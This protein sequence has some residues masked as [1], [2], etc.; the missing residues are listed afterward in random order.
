MTIST[1]G[2]IRE[3]KSSAEDVFEGSLEKTTLY[4]DEFGDF[5]KN[6]FLVKSS[7]LSNLLRIG[8]SVLLILILYVIVKYVCKQDYIENSEIKIK[9][10]TLAI[11]LFII[12]C[13]RPIYFMIRNAQLIKIDSKG[14]QVLSDFIPWEEIK[15][16]YIERRSSDSNTDYF[17]LIKS[18]NKKFRS[19][20][21]YGIENRKYISHIVETF[22]IK[23]G[24]TQQRV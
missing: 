17:L 8:I 18:E 20:I 15:E 6:E 10:E 13:I 22:R 1:W 12:S 7:L 23:Y 24:S 16:T 9:T 21:D 2:K 11:I 5:T 19:L 4:I 3:I 14:I